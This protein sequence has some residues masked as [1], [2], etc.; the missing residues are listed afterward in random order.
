MQNVAPSRRLQQR[1]RDLLLA[2]FVAFLCGAG[3]LALGLA[4][5]FINLVVPYNRGFD[6]YDL[7]R[8]S[9]LLLGLIVSVASML[10]AL[11]AVAWRTDHAGARQV[12]EI[13]AAR[14]D[15]RFVFIRNIRRPGLGRLDAALIS[16]HGVLLLKISGRKGA[17]LNDGG[18]W[19]RRGRRGDWRIL[20]WNPTREALRDAK[21]L[22][23]FLADQQLSQVPVYA[24]V[25]FTRDAPAASLVQ[26]KAALP[27]AHAT[28]LTEVLRDSYF[29]RSRLDQRATQAVVD[30]LYP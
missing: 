7:A 20:R 30:L 9:L 23:A 29:A 27:A 19:L 8:K 10:M 5:H 11:R 21:R 18:H 12:G 28:E 3:L 25:V 26:R 14:L 2:A 24:A 16:G 4:L 13:L 22:K 6:A 15:R 1:S 17:F